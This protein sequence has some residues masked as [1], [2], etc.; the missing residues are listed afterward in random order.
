MESQRQLLP[1]KDEPVNAF[2]NAPDLTNA[3]ASIREI[4]KNIQKMN[5]TPK[6]ERILNKYKT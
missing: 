5:L 1:N 6:E 4:E 2:R 3:N